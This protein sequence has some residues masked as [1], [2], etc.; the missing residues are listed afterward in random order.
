MFIFSTKFH[1]S[2][3]YLESY[4]RPPTR[5]AIITANLRIHVLTVVQI[6]TNLTPYSARLR[7][8]FEAITELI[9]KQKRGFCASN[10]VCL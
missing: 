5:F 8:C 7:N 9:Y 2:E 4:A 6:K 3:I 10:T 1:E